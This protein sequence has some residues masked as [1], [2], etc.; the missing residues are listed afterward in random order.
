MKL[1]EM[2][3]LSENGS[4]EMCGSEK[5]DGEDDSEDIVHVTKG[6]ALDSMDE[7]EIYRFKSKQYDPNLLL[8]SI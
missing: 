8:P 3:L 2:S 6:L 4:I 5:F 1:K 7:F